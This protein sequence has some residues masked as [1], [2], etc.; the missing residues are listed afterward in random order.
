MTILH[1]R[2]LYIIFIMLFFIITPAISFYAAGYSF[3]FN[4]GE[5]QRTG[6]LIIK[7][8]PKDALVNLGENQKFNWLY[9]FFYQGS[10]LRTPQKLRNLLAGKYDIT[11][12]KDGYFQY[13]RDVEI[14]SGE[15]VILDNILLFKNAW[16]ENLIN[17]NIIKTKLSPD[18]NKL[19]IVSESELTILNLSDG[20]MDR[21]IL[22]NNFSTQNFDILWAPSNK[23]LLLTR[24]NFPVFNIESKRQEMTIKEY[25]VG[26][27]NEVVWDDFSDSEIYI[28]QNLGIYFFDLISKNKKLV[29][30]KKT[31]KFL[32]KDSNIY[33][34]E[35]VNNDNYLNIYRDNKVIKSVSVP[36]VSMYEFTNLNN[37][38]IYLHDQRHDILY[39][40]DPWS[41]F[42]IQDAINGVKNFSL[43][44][45]DK[46]LYW[47]N[48]EIWQYN[49]NDKDKILIT[50]VS[51]NINKAL[52]HP[53]QYNIIYNTSNGVNAI[54]LE[55]GKYLDSSKI[56]DWAGTSDMVMSQNG[57]KLYFL[58][59][60]DNFR[61]LYSLDIK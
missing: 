59:R 40:I 60:T 37:N 49:K 9:N 15:T 2:I 19:A 11:L 31:E 57:E 22:D 7:T 20:N 27:I 30:N 10:E 13:Q 55:D 41:I 35:K 28:K 53:S 29:L 25:V 21:M 61:T 18:K 39:I 12:T 48:Y 46:I 36:V 26:D 3:D 14:N 17:Q 16:P 8:D 38:F 33:I 42:P 56:L 52:W 1:R 44:N 23:R 51:E 24:G 32:V 47:N 58:S 34:I 4:S 6:I 45:E 54:E 50:R 5:V 43:I